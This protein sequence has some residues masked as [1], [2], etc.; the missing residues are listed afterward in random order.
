M[1]VC[2]CVLTI[3]VVGEFVFFKLYNLISNVQISN[4][5]YINNILAKILSVYTK[6][7]LNYKILKRL[8]FVIQHLNTM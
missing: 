1:C 6:V 2:V 5:I 8:I 4:Y 7:K 3:K